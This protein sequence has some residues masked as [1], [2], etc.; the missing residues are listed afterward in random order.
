MYWIS[1]LVSP[2]QIK[3]RAKAAP[4]PRS[5]KTERRIPIRRVTDG[6]VPSIHA[7]SQETAFLQWNGGAFSA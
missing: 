4:A 7:E 3:R 2:Q 1:S 6:W 5:F